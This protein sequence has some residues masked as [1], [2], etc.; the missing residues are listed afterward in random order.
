MPDV[1]ILPLADTPAAG[2]GQRVTGLIQAALGNPDVVATHEMVDELILAA[3]AMMAVIHLPSGVPIRPPMSGRK[4][5]DSARLAV[6]KLAE[7]MLS[8]D[9]EVPS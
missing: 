3:A 4:I 7:S 8:N 9:Q 5:T 1:L 2:Y 6:A